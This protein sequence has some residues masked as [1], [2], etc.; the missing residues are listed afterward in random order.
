MHAM[1][2]MI[3]PTISL[4]LHV[5][6][7]GILPEL[8]T[9]LLPSSIFHAPHGMPR[10]VCSLLGRRCA[11]A[12]ARAPLP[13]HK[14]QR[15]HIHVRVTHEIEPRSQRTYGVICQSNGHIPDHRGCCHLMV[16]VGARP[17]DHFTHPSR[18][19]LLGSRGPVAPSERGFACY[20][21]SL[22]PS[23]YGER[24]TPIPHFHPSLPCLTAHAQP[25]DHA[26]YLLEGLDLPK[27]RRDRRTGRERLE[28]VR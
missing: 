23:L 7:I 4:A 26:R 10:P 5:T 16:E 22:Y 25:R 13:A 14:S 1:R 19:P 17:H 18:I 21:P 6:C 12:T 24:D 15:T 28:G 11:R 20:P 27:P 3:A 9:G 8:L 2:P